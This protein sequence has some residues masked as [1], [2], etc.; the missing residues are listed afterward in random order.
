M[1]NV[2]DANLIGRQQ[3]VHP[4]TM[5]ASSNHLSQRHICSLYMYLDYS[6]YL[7]EDLMTWRWTCCTTCP[8]S[9]YINR[10]FDFISSIAVPEHRLITAY[11]CFSY[12]FY[13]YFVGSKMHYSGFTKSNQCNN[14]M[15]TMSESKNITTE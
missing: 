1:Y 5:R 4:Y 10:Q 14:T 12:R 15:K 13:N 11:G 7:Q 6:R 8:R 9:L 3:G 2:K